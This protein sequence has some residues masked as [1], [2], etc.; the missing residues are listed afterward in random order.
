MS[1]S[2]SRARLNEVYGAVIVICFFFM[3]AIMLPLYNKALFSGL[4]QIDIPPFGHPL[5]ATAIQL[6]AL[7]I[8]LVGVLVAQALYN[9][10][11]RSPKQQVKSFA[12]ACEPSLLLVPL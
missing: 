11:I 1:S 2:L 6:V 8:L 3:A 9:A 10:I 12:F 7:C 5:T 4:S